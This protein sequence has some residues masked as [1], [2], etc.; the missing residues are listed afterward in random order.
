MTVSDVA[1]FHTG[2]S[3]F[4]S[5]GIAQHLVLVDQSA[6]LISGFSFAFVTLSGVSGTVG[7]TVNT[8][9]QAVP[10]TAAEFLN[11][12]LS[13]VGATESHLSTIYEI[14]KK[15]ILYDPP[16][17]TATADRVAVQLSSDR[18]SATYT[19]DVAPSLPPPASPPPLPSLPPPTQPTQLPPPHPPSQRKIPNW[20][21]QSWACG[22]REA[23][24][25]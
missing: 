12:P 4:L 19:I 2:D 24:T 16:C 13:A 20:Q 15:H 5:A 7:E 14:I 11:P 21:F 3:V 10:P 8:L 23:Q 1:L 6:P 17:P 25:N 22:I 18:L 9:T